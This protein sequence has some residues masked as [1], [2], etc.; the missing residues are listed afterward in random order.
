MR[1]IYKRFSVIAGFAVLLVV[2]LINTAIT[3]QRLAVQDSNQAWVTHTQ[4]VML[5][6]TTVE[7]LL[8]DAESGQRGFLYT[9]EFRYLAPYNTALAQVTP[10]IDKLAELTADNPRQ[11]PR[12]PTLRALVQ[13]K[14]DELQ[15]TITLFEAG[16]H[17]EAR[18][19]VLTDRGRQI[20][21]DLRGLTDQMRNDESAL[22]AARL[23][24]VR[25]STT[26]L[27]ATMYL[28]TALAMIGLV[29]LAFYILRE[30]V[31][32]E[33]HAAEIR[34]REEWFRVTLGS[35]GDGVIATDERGKVIFMNAIAEDLI[36]IPLAQARGQA[37]H[38]VFP[39][40]NEQTRKPVDN[41]VA[42]VLELGRVMGLANHTVLQRADG[43]I[44]PIEDSAAPIY[45]DQKRLRGVVMVF[46]DVTTEK[47]AQD[48]MRKAEKLATAGRLAATVAHEINNPLEA[49][50]NLIYI[51]K[52][53][54]GLPR[55]ILEY[56]TIAETELERVSHITRQTLGFYRDSS[57]PE[58]VQVR[59]VVESVLRLYDNKMRSKGISVELN[60]VD[61]PP[62]LGL[63]GELKQ[64]IA[65]LVSNAADA[66][67]QGG[68]IRISIAPAVRAQSR[69]V[70]ISVADNGPGV[71]VEN[72]MHIFEPFF[73]TKQDV[74]TGL[75]LW[76][77]KEIAERHGGSIQLN[78]NREHSLGGAVFTVF[79][80]LE[81]A[82]EAVGGVA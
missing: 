48:V 79:L 54:A 18:A 19:E 31:Q 56:L 62:V 75:G 2:L 80:R 61:S 47:Q 49:V 38:K 26:S 9:G 27:I 69:G 11:Q 39:I 20:M 66:V 59:S 16:K 41:P 24:A 58:P 64:L 7:S 42:K 35:I 50:G 71:A 70:E 77:S 82:A 60:H 13:Q 55:E 78:A 32:R 46:R 34:Q 29:L 25:S 68:R 4:Q 51:V 10:H 14:L 30:M 74:G 5:E 63:Q 57:V 17:Q 21:Q 43:K 81:A 53:T 73:T 65:N 33:K 8:A 1:V 36:G 44:I 23:E 3:R 76:V 72:R 37:V 12:I 15:K 6:L 52:N 28:T 67:G 40:F 22:E 45:D